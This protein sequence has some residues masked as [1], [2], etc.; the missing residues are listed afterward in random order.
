MLAEDGIKAAISDYYT[1]NPHARP[2]NLAG[3][4]MKSPTTETASSSTSAA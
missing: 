3:T 2:T 4:E 1:K